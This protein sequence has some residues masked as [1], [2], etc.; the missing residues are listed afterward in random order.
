MSSAI[1]QPEGPHL[2]DYD[3]WNRSQG[4]E[5]YRKPRRPGEMPGRAPS[6]VFETAENPSLTAI[7][8]SSGSSSPLLV[9]R[10]R[11]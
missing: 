10:T 1:P 2:D 3:D 4:L 11:S 5:A 7:A 6:H 9:L 8:A